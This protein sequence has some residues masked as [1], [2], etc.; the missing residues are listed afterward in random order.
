M[1]NKSKKI[2]AE[3]PAMGAYFHSECVIVFDENKNK[4][5]CKCVNDM[6]ECDMSQV[7]GD[8]YAFCPLYEF[9]YN[10]KEEDIK[11]CFN[12]LKYARKYKILNYRVLNQIELEI[13]EILQSA[14]PAE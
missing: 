8:M 1:E 6:P 3:L 11:R 2:I 9:N 10:L 12:F 4:I 5:Y 14:Q 7:N 13:L